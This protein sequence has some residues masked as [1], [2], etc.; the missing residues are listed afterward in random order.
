[1]AVYTVT[2]REPTPDHI[3]ERLIE[4]IPA[5]IADRPPTRLFWPLP[6][7]AKVLKSPHDD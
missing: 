2:K 4:A 7:P 6:K 3:M 5:I 1:M